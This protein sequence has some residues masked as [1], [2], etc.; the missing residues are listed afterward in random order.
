MRTE[1]RVLAGMDLHRL[2]EIRTSFLLGRL[3]TYRNLNYPDPRPSNL[4][5]D[6]RRLSTR[7]S[8][9]KTRVDP[10]ANAAFARRGESLGRRSEAGL[11]RVLD[12]LVRWLRSA[13]INSQACGLRGRRIRWVPGRPVRRDEFE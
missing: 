3:D 7:P 11:R 12:W 2:R 6:S 9:D 13:A 4:A 10:P 5:A 8:L 1:C